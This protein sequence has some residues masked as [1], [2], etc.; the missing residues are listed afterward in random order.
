[1]D[2]LDKNVLQKEK[3]YSKNAKLN[4]KYGNIFYFVHI[5]DLH[6]SRYVPSNI[7]NLR[8]FL[9]NTMKLVGPS[10][11]VVSGDLTDAKDK[12]M[13]ASY[14]HEIE[15]KMYQKILDEHNITSDKWF[16]VRGNHDC[17]DVPEATSPLNFFK[18]YSRS[19]KMEYVKTIRFP[20]GEYSV[21]SLDGCPNYGAARPFNFFG[22]FDDYDLHNLQINLESA[23]DSNHIFISNHY[24]LS[25]MMF[26]KPKDLSQRTFQ[27]MTADV[28]MLLCGHLHKLIG[29][30]AHE[31][32][33]LHPNGL[34]EL[35]IGDMKENSQFRIIAVDHDLLSFYDGNIYDDLHIVILNPKDSRFLMPSKEPIHLIKESSH[36]RILVFNSAN[37]KNIQCFIDGKML[38]S[39]FKRTLDTNLWSL[40]WNPHQYAKGIHTIKITVADVHG[41]HK[42]VGNEFSLDLTRSEVESTGNI[43]L[44]S[45]IGVYF[46]SK[47]VRCIPEVTQ[48]LPRLEK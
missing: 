25:T 35:E 21:I 7:K 18:K 9:S 13:L 16:D 11:V 47:V 12:Y 26:K 1:M 24:P 33:A 38:P 15:W 31:M 27:N 48:E 43:I 41:K 34:T 6:V 40:E 45:R 20:F 46:N 3:K 28:S 42:S 17:F 23:K 39:K 30:L 29:G 2:K 19:K 4:E 44:E 5:S 14:Q 37:I 10:F 32:Y 8:Y 36:I 22:Y